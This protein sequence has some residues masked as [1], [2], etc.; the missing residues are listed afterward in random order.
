MKL[1]RSDISNYKIKFFEEG[2]R[3]ATSNDFMDFNSL[4]E[5]FPYI[6]SDLHYELMEE[7][8]KGFNLIKKG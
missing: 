8:I 5:M 3:Q 2:K 6:E 1:S 4:R 7:F